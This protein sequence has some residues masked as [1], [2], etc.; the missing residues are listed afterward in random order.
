VYANFM[1]SPEVLN[2]IGQK[3]GIPGDQLYA[4]G[5]VDPLVPRI[6]EEPTAVQRNVEITGETD[7]YRLNFNNDP[8]LPTIGIYAQAPTTAVAVRLADAAVEG[9]KEYVASLQNAEKVPAPSRVVIRQLGQP[10]G[11]V[12]DSGIKKSL[13][14]LVFVGVF[15]LWSILALT[16]TRF[17]T[18]WRASAVL[19]GDVPDVPVAPREVKAPRKAANGKPSNG[20]TPVAA[21]VGGPRASLRRYRGRPEQEKTG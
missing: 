19:V 14:V 7:P 8:D 18:A 11:G 15:L 6:V 12:V 1:A 20:R 2:E 16:L 4:A 17:R 10:T 13:A 3:A 5:P 21:P 9:L